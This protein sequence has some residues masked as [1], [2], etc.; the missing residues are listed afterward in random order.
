MILQ[1]ITLLTKQDPEQKSPAVCL[2]RYFNSEPIQEACNEMT[3]ASSPM[4]DLQ[5][6][7]AKTQNYGN[8]SSFSGFA[9]QSARRKRIGFLLPN[10]GIPNS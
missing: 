10:R 4:G 5:R 1:Q 2:A 6:M 3:G 9:P 7:V 8:V